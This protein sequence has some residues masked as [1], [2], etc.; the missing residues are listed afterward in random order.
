[1]MKI[2]TMTAVSGALTIALGC[3]TAPA[4]AQASRTWVSGVGDDVNP[5]SR[6]APCKT[7][8]GAI[9]RTAA[10]GEIN[11]L[12][13][14]GFG[15]VT[16]TRSI[17]IDCTGTLGGV[18]ASNTTGVILNGA[19][20]HVILRGLSIS[21]G[22]PTLPGV[23]GI[24]FL[25][26]GSLTV[27][28]SIIENFNAAAPNGNGMT[29]APS[30]SAQVFVS[31]TQIIGNLNSGIIVQP[32]GAGNARVVL[33]NVVM[34]RNTGAGLQVNTTGN[35]G[36]GVFVTVSDSSIA[37]SLNGINVITAAGTAPG[38][39]TVIGSNISNN[40]TAALNANGAGASIR[41]GGSTMAGNGA[42]AVTTASGSVRS[43]GDNYVTN[44]SVDGTFTAP[45]VP[46]L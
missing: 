44:N 18:L 42:A 23:H 43:F 36:T 46:K 7:L 11:C 17:T 9:S 8:A 31:N 30:G 29:I 4:A 19:N 24:R 32:T 38:L 12:D 37:G 34:A 40:P 13:P 21:G 33:R 5:C 2:R 25:Q 27:E 1:M 26:S 28:D 6:T 14:G 16:I 35:T 22:P 20:I 15:A 39:V 41:V 3:Y 45:A 10:G